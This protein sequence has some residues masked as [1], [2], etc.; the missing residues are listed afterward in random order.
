M[1]LSE[2][3]NIWMF[4]IFAWKC[5]SLGILRLNVEFVLSVLSIFKKQLRLFMQF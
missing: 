3:Q 4:F 1:Y 5:F 2:N